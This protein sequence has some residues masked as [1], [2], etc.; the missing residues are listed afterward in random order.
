M[1][2][3]GKREDLTPEKKWTY[4]DRA[5]QAHRADALGRIVSRIDN[6]TIGMNGPKEMLEIERGQVGKG[7]RIQPQDWEN[8][9]SMQDQKG[10]W[11]PRELTLQ[12]RSYRRRRRRLEIF[13]QSHRKESVSVGKVIGRSNKK[14]Q[15]IAPTKNMDKMGKETQQEKGKIEHTPISR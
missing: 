10:Q 4:L 13:G 1:V 7:S 14:S 9:R 8:R 12:P 15:K 2:L 3:G 11:E 6:P 5:L